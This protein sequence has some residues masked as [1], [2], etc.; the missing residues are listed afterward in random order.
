MKPIFKTRYKQNRQNKSTVIDEQR[1]VLLIDVDP[2]RTSLLKRALK[3]YDYCITE[4]L[5]DT[6]RL[7]KSIDSDPPNIIIVGVDLPDDET[8]RQL[9]LLNQHFPLP[10]IMFAES[11]TPKIIEKVID[12]GVSAF[13]VKDIQPQRIPSIISIATTRFT[14]QQ[15]LKSELTDVQ[16][17]LADRKIIEKSKGLLMSHKNI[18]E[19]DAFHTIRKMAMNRNISLADAAKNIIDVL[20]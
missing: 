6:A 17:K 8:I 4:V 3:E 12:A 5:K 9:A 2:E 7:L 15:N 14:A 18:S 19:G 10:V 11:D 1:K 16:N 13:I 20:S